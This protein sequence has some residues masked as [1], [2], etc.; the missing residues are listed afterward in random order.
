MASNRALRTAPHRLRVAKGK[1]SRLCRFQWSCKGEQRHQ[2]FNNS[3]G[4]KQHEKDRR[5]REQNPSCVLISIQKRQTTVC[6]SQPLPKT[7]P[8]LS[9]KSSLLN[10]KLRVFCSGATSHV[11]CCRCILK[12]PEKVH[13]P[14]LDF[15]HRSERPKC[16]Y[17]GKNVD[18]NIAKKECVRVGRRQIPKDQ[19][20]SR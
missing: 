8:L 14:S 10:T 12:T 9:I 19:V 17:Q 1:R 3:K 4:Q 6:A 16:E 20:Q 7:D 15:I 11:V 5:K 13:G 2:S 18:G